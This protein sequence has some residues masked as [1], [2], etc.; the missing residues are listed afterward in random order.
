MKVERSDILVIGAGPAGMCA[1]MYGARAMLRTVVLDKLAPGGELLNTDTI[2]DYPGFG[3]IKGSELSDKMEAQAREFG[4]EFVLPV[5]VTEVFKEGDDCVARTSDDVEYRAPALVL[6]TGGTPRK[7]KIPG[8]EEYASKG[9]SYC[10]LCDGAFFRDQVV[11]VI[12]GGDAAVEE[13]D[14]LTR[15]ASVVRLVHRRDEFRA[16]PVI[17]ERAKKNPKLEYRMS[18]VTEEIRGNGVVQ[19]IVL[20]DVKTGKITE[21]KA[22]G[23]FIF[24]G[25]TPNSDLLKADCCRDDLGFLMTDE[26]MMTDIPGI[27]AAGDVRHQPVRQITN[28]VGDATT[29]AVSAQ[30]F[31]EE[32]YEK[33]GRDYWK[34]GATA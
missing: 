32:L 11:Y 13:A 9:V 3:L 8:E 1:G 18:M 5:E 21:E 33:K 26:N 10:A 16:Q 27:Y 30:K 7:L 29:A 23:V 6:T 24:V 19:S 17:V 15:Y 4:A 2:E 31:V 14:F 28:A 22:E 20:K 34:A 12:G 25:F